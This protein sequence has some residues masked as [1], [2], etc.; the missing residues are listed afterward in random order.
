MRQRHRHSGANTVGRIGNGDGH[1]I[2]FQLSDR[3]IAPILI[4][5]RDCR[6]DAHQRGGN[7]RGHFWESAQSGNTHPVLGKKTRKGLYLID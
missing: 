4:S 2:L 1:T 3:V 6:P 7:V 5:P